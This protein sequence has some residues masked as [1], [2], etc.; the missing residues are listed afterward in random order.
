MAFKNLAKYKTQTILSVISLAVGFVC[1]TL[2]SLWRNYENSYD[3]FHKDY[4]RIYM[5]GADNSSILDTEQELRGNTFLLIDLMKSPDVEAVAPF[6]RRKVSDIVSV[7][8]TILMENN[9]LSIDTSFLKVFD[10]ELLEGSM[11]FLDKE[12]EVA[13]SDIFAKKY[14]GAESPLGKEIKI[15]AEYKYKIGA[16]FKAYDAHSQFAFDVIRKYNLYLGTDFGYSICSLVVKLKKG[17]A[18][19][20]FAPKLA[21]MGGFNGK[22]FN[23]KAYPI[24]ES[25]RYN[26]KELKLEYAHISAF[27]FASLMLAVC[28]VINFLVLYLIRLRNRSREI[29]LRMACGSSGKQILMLFFLEYFMVLLAASL[30]A[31]AI[32]LVIAPEF[33]MFTG[34]KSD[35]NYLLVKCVQY[36]AVI[37]A[38][39]FA[40]GMLPINHIRR[41]TLQHHLKGRGSKQDNM[42]RISLFVQFAV[43]I[44]FIFC[45]LVMI[46]QLQYMHNLNI[47]FKYKG[48]AYLYA[49]WRDNDNTGGRLQEDYLK[50]IASQ[51]EALPM[52]KSVKP[53]QR[54]FYSPAKG[55]NMSLLK[56][57]PTG[58]PIEYYVIGGITDIADPFY[59]V[60]LLEGRIP[61]REEWNENEIVVTENVCK[62]LGLNDAVGKT[63]YRPDAEN[64][65]PVVIAGVI[66][67]IY[68]GG[69]KDEALPYIF[70]KDKGWNSVSTN[71]LLFDFESDMREELI[72]QIDEIY[73]Q[74]PMLRPSMD[75]LED[76]F[77]EMFKSEDNLKSILSIITV[78]CIVVS[79]FGIYAIVTLACT[80]RRKEI[81][82]RKVNGAVVKDIL[83]IFVKEYGVIVALASIVAFASG[84]II[85]KDW[86]AQYV[87][88]APVSW[89]IYAVVFL[90]VISLIAVTVGSRVLKTA[91]ENPAE[92]LKSE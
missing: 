30:L 77:D 69:L 3:T 8:G 12:D 54:D 60:T 67:D 42:W 2:S 18:I 13:I 29:A 9:I 79:M 11:N 91:R 55:V 19:A 68:D 50:E 49:D 88:Q 41:S 39:C 28:A 85:M 73:K 87:K 56:A 45:T 57:T 53:H 38:V 6:N 35:D 80:Q 25:H 63:V 1:L 22:E 37:M 24:T 31:L 4:E 78:V 46:N 84:Y 70:E 44:C 33:T 81:A 89:W 21:K 36:I 72:V 51:L 92:V 52:V 74:Y 65:E 76:H 47:G 16:V 7:D 32:I 64:W 34:I 90:G 59:G 40:V 58:E 62:R 82:I 20:D 61:T 17:V 66:K 10:L 75:F 27:T 15:G 23:A 26:N 86:I 14:F 48:H 71:A 83:K 43:S 5:I